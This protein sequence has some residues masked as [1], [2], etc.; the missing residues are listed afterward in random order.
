MG[1]DPQSPP[2]TPGHTD[3]DKLDVGLV[4]AQ[5]VGGCTSEEGVIVG[6]RH[7]GDGQEAAVDPALV[8]GVLC[9]PEEGGGAQEETPGLETRAEAGL[10]LSRPLAHLGS[11]RSKG[12]PFFV[13]VKTMLGMPRARQWRV[14]ELVLSPAAATL[15]RGVGCST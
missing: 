13:Q 12:T 11:W 10:L 4:R 9:V 15:V 7:I 8:V 6:S 3:A 1:A 14:A 5:G 2:L